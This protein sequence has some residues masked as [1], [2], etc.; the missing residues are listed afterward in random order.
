VI[1]Y[2]HQARFNPE[3]DM[4]RHP[5]DDPD[6]PLR[7]VFALRTNYRPNAIGMTT[8]RLL[9]VDDNVLTVQG[10]DALD[11]T[12]ILDIKPH[13]PRFDAPPIPDVA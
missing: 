7:G 10:L 4:Q 13:V 9:R 11:G 5:Q 6:Q 2:L 3:V 12:P 8:V 1:F